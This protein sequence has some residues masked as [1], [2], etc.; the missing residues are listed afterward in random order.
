MR[1]P[2]PNRRVWELG[3]EYVEA[4]EILLD[5]NRLQPAVI[6]AALAAEIL[7]KSFLAVGDRKGKVTTEFGHE[8]TRLFRSIDEKD[9]IEIAECFGQIDANTNLYDGLGR[10][11]QVFESARYRYEPTAPVSIGSDVIHFARHLCDAVLLLGKRR[12]A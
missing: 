6:L 11:D 2:I 3:L 5:Y 8:L 7:L 4:A 12:S 9:R 1:Q 10:F